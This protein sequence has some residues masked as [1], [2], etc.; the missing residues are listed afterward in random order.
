MSNTDEILK[1]N[2]LKDT[3]NLIAAA[4]ISKGQTIA[5]TDTFRSYANKINSISTAAKIPA[6]ATFNFEGSMYWDEE[7]Q[8]E[9]LAPKITPENVS[10]LEDIDTSELLSHEN[11]LHYSTITSCP[12]IDTS[13]SLN[14]GGMFGTCT[15]LVTAPTLDSTNVKRMD[16]MFNGCTALVNVPVYDTSNILND[17]SRW[18]P[19]GMGAMFLDCPNLSNQSLNNIMQMCINATQYV[20]TTSYGKDLGAL[21]LT[22]EQKGVCETLSNYPAFVAAGWT[23]GYEDETS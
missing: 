4:I 11:F 18:E 16:N 15:S 22:N 9:V 23:S 5:S 17:G 7:Q 14:F 3:K 20:A 21:G 8:T 2:Y 13:S 6:M 10:I 12:A 19:H 1:L